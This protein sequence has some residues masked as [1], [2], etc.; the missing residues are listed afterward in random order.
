MGYRNQHINQGLEEFTHLFNRANS[1]TVNI[2]PRAFN[3]IAVL[4]DTQGSSSKQYGVRQVLEELQA[5][6]SLNIHWITASQDEATKLE[7]D[8]LLKTWEDQL[9]FSYFERHHGTIHPADHTLKILESL[10][11]DLLIAPSLFGEDAPS[12]EG[13]TLGSTLDKVL[14][15]AKTPVL[16]VEGTLPEGKSSIFDQVLCYIESEQQSQQCWDC[17]SGIANKE[18]AVNFVHVMEDDWIKRVQE[19]IPVTKGTPI[20]NAVETFVEAHQF[21]YRHYLEEAREAFLQLQFSGTNTVTTGD[22]IV[23][24]KEHLKEHPNSLIV[25]NSVA[26]DEKL[27]DSLAYNLAAYLTNTPIL[28]V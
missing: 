26:P 11:L 2:E 13:Y 10:N 8:T 24:V 21:H 6:N 16:L 23:W 27:V 22:P 20:L 1:P 9:E 4:V 5:R 15:L 25:C 17:C 19:A 12:L 7:Q 14:S 18:A 3:N 28:L